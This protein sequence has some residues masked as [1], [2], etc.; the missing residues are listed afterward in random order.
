MAELIE[1]GEFVDFSDALRFALALEASG[2]GLAA[3]S[4]SRNANVFLA[5]I[6]LGLH[7]AHG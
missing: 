1:A 7:F 2:V 5:R 6:C 3:A 4:S